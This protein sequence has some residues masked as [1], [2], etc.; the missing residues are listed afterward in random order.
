ML[1]QRRGESAILDNAHVV[2]AGRA[3]AADL[4]GG[5]S[6]RGLDRAA[7]EVAV[8]LDVEHDGRPRGGGAASRVQG[9]VDSFARQFRRQHGRPAAAAEVV[10]MGRRDLGARGGSWVA[11]LACGGG[12]AGAAAEGAAAEVCPPRRV[13]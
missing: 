3:G 10:L 1:G 12:R 5:A 6:A 13:G 9:V 7:H 11:G 8:Q 2:N 4:Q